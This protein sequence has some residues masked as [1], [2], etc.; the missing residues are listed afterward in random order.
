MA[1]HNRSIERIR[2]RESIDSGILVEYRP[3]SA[4][5]ERR[6]HN[7]IFV[8]IGLSVSGGRIRVVNRRSVIH[9]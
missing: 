5:E 7:Q 1:R 4:T 8:G 6:E 3:G 2:P 9:T